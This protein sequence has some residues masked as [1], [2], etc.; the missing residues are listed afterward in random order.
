M[1]QDAATEGLGARSRQDEYNAVATFLGEVVSA[2]TFKNGFA[3]TYLFKKSYISGSGH[4]EV[5][6][7]PP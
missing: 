4:H 2:K 1:E 7:P 5:N 6:V 3:F